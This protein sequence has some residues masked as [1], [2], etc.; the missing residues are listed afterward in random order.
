MGNVSRDV[1]RKKRL[2]MQTSLRVGGESSSIMPAKLN[3]MVLRKSFSDAAT[4]LLRIHWGTYDD[5]MCTGIGS[6]A[7]F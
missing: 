4:I 7:Q 6:A 5:T 1:K 3:Q 2:E